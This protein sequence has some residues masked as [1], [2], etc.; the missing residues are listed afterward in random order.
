[1]TEQEWLESVDRDRLGRLATL[2][3]TLEVALSPRKLWLYAIAS[4]RLNWHRLDDLRA[5]NAI[6]VTER[7]AEGLASRKAFRA[8]CKEAEKLVSEAEADGRLCRP[9]GD[10]WPSVCARELAGWICDPKM[11]G[12][13]A[14]AAAGWADDA[15][16]DHNLHLLDPAAYW[17]ATAE[18]LEARAKL[19]R[20]IFGNPFRPVAL[21]PAWRTATVLA[22]ARAAYEE[23]SLPSGILDAARL[24]ILADALEDAGCSEP[25]ILSHL[26]GP[27]PHVRGCWVVDLLL[28][29]E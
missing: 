18:K 12:H 6:E 15:A 11:N 26:R 14:D 10:D 9:R 27:G 13:C 1:M 21:D 8:A 28:E 29:R 2:E 3:V 24:S 17:K 5:R 20:E 22:L 16:V 23:R 19:S 7:F 25:A 4:A